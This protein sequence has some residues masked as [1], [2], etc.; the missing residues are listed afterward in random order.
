MQIQVFIS[1]NACLCYKSFLF[2]SVQLLGVN[3]N[4]EKGQ[5][6]QIWPEVNSYVVTEISIEVFHV[7]M[8]TIFI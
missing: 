4:S 5:L 2:Q 8:Q 1:L 3:T 6:F 7:N